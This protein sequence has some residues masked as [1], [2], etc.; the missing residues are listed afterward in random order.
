M[1][2]IGDFVVNAT[3]GI[4]K[5]KEIIHME[6]SGE[7]K[8]YFLLVPIEEETAK[9]FI[10]VDNAANRIRP[11][12]DEKMANDVLSEVKDIKPLEVTVE[13]EREACYKNAIKSCDPRQLVS[14]MKVI[15]ERKKERALQ[16]KKTTAV[17]ERYGKIA[18]SHLQS[19]LAFVLGLEKKDVAGK[20]LQILEMREA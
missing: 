16:G 19:E 18:D 9:V 14:L 2:E 8:P 13:R 11:M 17:D 7:Q 5:I 20:I 15:F 6:V 12:M 1:F 10:P 3:N 4:C